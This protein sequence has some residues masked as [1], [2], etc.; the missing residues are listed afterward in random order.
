MTTT[1]R[2]DLESGDL[3][4]ALCCHRERVLLAG[5]GPVTTSRVVFPVVEI[6][7]RDTSRIRV[8]ID[9]T[10]GLVASVQ[11]LGHPRSR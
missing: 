5:A 3:L 2:V 1:V 9:S 8:L 10:S 6:T 11:T 4:G 7:Y